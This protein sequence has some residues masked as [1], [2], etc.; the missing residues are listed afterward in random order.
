MNIVRTDIDAVNA[1]LTV[2]IEKNDYAENVEKK[3]RE[4]RKKANIPG[5][6]PGMVPMGMLKKMYGK[7]ILAEEIN[8]LISENLYKYIS[9][10]KIESLGEPLPNEAEQPEFDLDANEEFDFIFRYWY[11]ARI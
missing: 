7:A 4:Y 8:S 5:F 9:E 6:R 2:H 3:L 10:N 1:T 11:R